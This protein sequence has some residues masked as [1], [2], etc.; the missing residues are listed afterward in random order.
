MED[1]LPD[2]EGGVSSQQMIGEPIVQ[3]REGQGDHIPSLG[4]GPM[5]GGDMIKL[6]GDPYGRQSNPMACR[7]PNLL[8][9]PCPSEA[10][11]YDSP[12]F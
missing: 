1:D 9:Q 7:N 12:S 8:S 4:G 2:E 11:P 5:E 6:E 10:N 3:I